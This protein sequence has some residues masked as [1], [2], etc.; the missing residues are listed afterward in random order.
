MKL[1]STQLETSFIHR[2]TY[3]N[4]SQ[5]FPMLVAI[6]M[7]LHASCKT[8][9]VDIFYADIT[10]FFVSCCCSYNSNSYK[11]REKLLLMI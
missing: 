6:A 5:F 7:N 11:H 4:E 3:K 9:A 1:F 10:F 8:V 2:R